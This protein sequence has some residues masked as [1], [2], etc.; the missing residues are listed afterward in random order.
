M[1]LE[2]GTTDINKLYLGSTEMNKC[3]LGSTVVYQ[4][5]AGLL[6]DTYPAEAAYSLRKLRT[7]YS[8]SAIRVRRSSDNSEQDIGFDGNDFDSTDLETFCGANDGF[9]VTWYDQSGNGNDITNAT[10]AQQPKAHDSSTGTITQAGVA[11]VK[12]DGSN[13]TLALP[14][15]YSTST[16][17]KSIFSVYRVNS[18]YSTLA[19]NARL[20]NCSYDGTDNRIYAGYGTAYTSNKVGLRLGG[21]AALSSSGDVST[22][23]LALLTTIADSSNGN[24][25]QDGTNVLNTTPTNGSG[26]TS[27]GVKISGTGNNAHDGYFSEFIIYESD[28]TSNRTSIESDINSYYGL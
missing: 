26:I 6:L 14:V 1:T 3:Y 12:F 11:S 15:D 7:A 27:A 21:S 23:G 28:E 20:W 22:S 2:L 4:K 16:Y 25:W 5:V 17:S 19:G 8:G 24:V 18:G 10:Q 9:V 13:D